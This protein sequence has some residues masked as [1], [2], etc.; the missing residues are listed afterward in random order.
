M[1]LPLRKCGR[2][3]E[4]GFFLFSFRFWA[5]EA[6][7]F[8]T[9]LFLSFLLFPLGKFFTSFTIATLTLLVAWYIEKPRE[10]SRMLS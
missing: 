10:G 8:A 4:E 6:P 3:N 5:P 7:P 2:S 1:K 9:S